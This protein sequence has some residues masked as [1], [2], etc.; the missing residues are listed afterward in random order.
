MVPDSSQPTR[1]DPLVEP[2][3]SSQASTARVPADPAGGDDCPAERTAA[4]LAEAVAAWGLPA[5]TD[6]PIVTSARLRTSLGLFDPRRMQIRLAPFLARA[7]DALF[8]EVVLHE[9]AHAAVRLVHG[10]GRRP[11]GREWRA[12][13]TAVGLAPRV[14]FDNPTPHP[15]WP[16]TRA[17]CALP[18]VRNT[19]Y[20]L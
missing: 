3:A 4:A 5:L 9:L 1:D 7:P 18:Y 6:V 12:F 11:H 10:P 16:A 15:A 14:R 2:P 8:R 20:S 13:M 19:P 17:A